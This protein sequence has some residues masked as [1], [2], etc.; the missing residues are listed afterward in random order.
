MMQFLK[1]SL[2]FYHLDWNR[3]AQF[4]Q[5]FVTWKC[6]VGYLKKGS[7]IGAFD[8]WILKKTLWIFMGEVMCLVSKC[9]VGGSSVYVLFSLTLNKKASL[10]FW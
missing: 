5:K 10:A 6:R 8:L 9:D 3:N 1:M 4:E 7:R 2:G